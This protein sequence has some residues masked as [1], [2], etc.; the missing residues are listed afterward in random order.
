MA[1]LTRFTVPYNLLLPDS[2]APVDARPL[3]RSIARSSLSTTR[4][5]LVQNFSLYFRV[6]ITEMSSGAQ[7]S[8][9]TVR[10]LPLTSSRDIIFAVFR[11]CFLL[12]WPYFGRFFLNVDSPVPTSLSESFVVPW[13]LSLI[14]RKLLV[15]C[16]NR[17]YV[18]LLSSGALSISFCMRWFR[19]WLR[20]AS[21]HSTTITKKKR[22]NFAIDIHNLAY[23]IISL[24]KRGSHQLWKVSTMPLLRSNASTVSNRSSRLPSLS[25][26][27]FFSAFFS[28]STEALGCTKEKREHRTTSCDDGA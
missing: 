9:E 24:I 16:R 14:S 10:F 15:R 8:Q 26:P 3:D 4:N 28:L 2:R 5:V 25:L 11:Y 20:T 23:D 19:S 18:R 7:N 6:A 22:R 12:S 17:R 1:G 27:W 21:V 13:E